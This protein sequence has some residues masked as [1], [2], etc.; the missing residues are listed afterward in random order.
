MSIDLNPPTNRRK[1]LLFQIYYHDVRSHGADAPVRTV[2]DRRCK[3]CL[4]LI[5]S[6]E[7]L[8]QLLTTEILARAL[9]SFNQNFCAAVSGNLSS[10][11]F[12]RQ[13][14]LF[15]ERTKLLNAGLI[16]RGKRN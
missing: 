3:S 13:L 8:D 6:F 11:K 4:I 15:R 2:S 16:A 1:L 7:R 5:K 12:F 9:Q 10:R 14:I